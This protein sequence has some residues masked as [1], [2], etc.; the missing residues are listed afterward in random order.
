MLDFD[1]YK[2]YNLPHVTTCPDL[3]YQVFCN[4][5]ETAA[6]KTIPRG[7]GNNY[8]LC[9]DAECENPSNELSCSLLRVTTQVWLL[10]LYLPNL[11][12]SGEI[13]GPKQ[14]IGASTFHTLVEKHGIF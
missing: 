5:I 3:S 13:D 6:K 2:C 1:K 14:L 9:W 4:I 10:Q 8:I 7:Y 12:G 11:T